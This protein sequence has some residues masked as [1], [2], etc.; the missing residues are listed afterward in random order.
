MCFLAEPLKAYTHAH[1]FDTKSSETKIVLDHLYQDYTEFHK[2]DPPVN[3]EDFTELG[4]S[5]NDNTAVFNLFCNLCSTYKCKA[6]TM[7]YNIVRI[8]NKSCEKINAEQSLL[9]CSAF[10]YH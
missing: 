2:S 3:S 1:H 5:K 8:S 6:F 4:F 10:I 7:A 9:E